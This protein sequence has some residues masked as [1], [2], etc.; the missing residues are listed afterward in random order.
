MKGLIVSLVL[1]FTTLTVVGQ[2][3]MHGAGLTIFVI[4]P[5]NG[6]VSVG[7]GF[8]YFPRFNFIETEALSVSA[9]I[10][11]SVGL[12]ATSSLTT[13]ME[14]I[15]TTTQLLALSLMPHLL[16]TLIWQRFYHGKHRENGLFCWRRLWF[17][18]R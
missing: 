1:F 8:T 4:S 2:S 9:G 18:S 12:T 15:M 14:D 10:P 11:L 6:D 5:R 16:L 17:P 13:Q 7:E 3:F